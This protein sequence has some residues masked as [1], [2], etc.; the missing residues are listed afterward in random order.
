MLRGVRRRDRPDRAKDLEL[1]VADRV[2][3]ERDRRLHADEGDQ[4]QEM[5]L[6]DV[7]QGPGL[8]VVRGT[9]LDAERLRD[10]DLDV[11]DVLPVPDRLEDPVREPKH[12]DVLHRLLA[13]V[14]IDAEDLILAEDLVHDAGELRRR[15][16][17]VTERL[18]DHDA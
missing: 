13:E 16:E 5:V 10:G 4:L 1:L 17:V 14:V 12:Q 7:A 11:V 8:F 3:V 2:R 9:L 18:L 15:R 6:D